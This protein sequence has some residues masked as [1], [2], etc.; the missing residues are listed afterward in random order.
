MEIPSL[1]T[2]EPE[3]DLELN[4]EHFVTAED[5]HA[6]TILDELRLRQKQD[7]F[8]CL[9]SHGEM[10][11]DGFLVAFPNRDSLWLDQSWHNG[12]TKTAKDGWAYMKNWAKERGFTSI[13]GETQRN[14]KRAMERLGFK[15]FS[16]IMKCDLRMQ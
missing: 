16:V 5:Y 13:T 8:F 4:K 3:L 14:E 11:I 1:I 12:D 6:D 2:F 10:G 15:E 9:V 7:N